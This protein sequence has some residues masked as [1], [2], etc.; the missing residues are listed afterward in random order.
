M[1]T[2]WFR[3]I[4]LILW[5]EST[6]THLQDDCAGRWS[7][8]LS[9]CKS[10][11]TIAENV[12]SIAQF[13]YVACGHTCNVIPYFRLWIKEIL[14]SGCRK[15]IFGRMD[16]CFWITDFACSVFWLIWIPHQ[17]LWLQVHL[18]KNYIHTLMDNRIQR[19]EV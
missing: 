1:Q 2:V 9:S 12:I 4:L 10:F 13:E 7:F 5:T 6:W 14:L 3:I 19:L 11:Y 8:V 17:W 15:W 16:A 18:F